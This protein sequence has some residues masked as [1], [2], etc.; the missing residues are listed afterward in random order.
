[1][2]PLNQALIHE[3]RCMARNGA[4]VPQMLRTVLA[5]GAHEQPY[6]VVFIKYLRGAFGL[7]L[8]QASP[9]GGWM[10]D[11]SGELSDSQ[12]NDL[13]MLEI[14]NNRPTWD[15]SEPVITS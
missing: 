10:P 5:R 2:E 4:T 8:R 15:A 12:L 11:S 14:L 9:I 7:T 13:L 6:T 3:L 1:M